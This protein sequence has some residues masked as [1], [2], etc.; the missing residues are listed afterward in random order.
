MG[1]GLK[2]LHRKTHTLAKLM[3]KNKKEKK[4]RGKENK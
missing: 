2:Y 1:T 3:V 4:G